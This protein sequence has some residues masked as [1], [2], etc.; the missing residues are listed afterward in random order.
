MFTRLRGDIYNFAPCYVTNEAQIDRM[1][2]ILGESID[3]VLGGR[4]QEPG[5]R[6]P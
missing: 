3:E 1:V 6:S 2:Q 4:S 5:A